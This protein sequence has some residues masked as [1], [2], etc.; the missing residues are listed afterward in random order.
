MTTTRGL[1]GALV[2]A[3][4]AVSVISAQR[5]PAIQTP[6]F[7][8]GT[9]YVSVDVIVTDKDDRVVTNLT[10]EDFEIAE[11]GIRQKIADFAVVSIP[12]ADRAV[13]VDAPP[14]PPSDVASN[15]RSADVSRAIAIVIDDV[16]IRGQD[17]IP[18]KRV[19]VEFLKKLTPDDQIALTWTS[20]SDLSQDFTSD[21]NRLIA[22]VNRRKA[23]V[24]TADF[25]GGR[26]RIGTLRSVVKAMELARQG[27]RAIFFVSGAAC[28]P[29]PVIEPDATSIVRNPDAGQQPR[30]AR[31]GGG[32]LYA[33]C[34]DLIKQAQRVGVAIYTVDPRLFTGA[35]AMAAISA[36]TPEERGALVSEARAADD[37][38]KTLAGATGGRAFSGIS[39]PLKA[40]EHIVRENGSYYLLGYYPDPLVDDGQFH[41]I[42]VLVKRPGLR[43]RARFGYMAPGAPSNKPTTETREMTRELGAGLDDPGLP[44]RA[45][46]APIAMTPK[47]TR[48]MVTVELTYPA[49]AG[50]AV[51]DDLRV[52]V[53]AITPDAKIKASFQ[54]PIHIS[55]K[56]QPDARGRFA[57]NEAIDLPAKQ[58]VLRIGVT[59]R[60]LGRSGTTH[61]SVDV[62]DFGDHDLQVS[63]LVI[64]LPGDLPPDAVMGLD[65]FRTLVPFQ[66]TTVRTFSPSG[67]IRVFSRAY[68]KPD[69]TPVDATLSLTGPTTRP[70]QRVTLQGMG[71]DRS[72]RRSAVFDRSVSLAGLAPGTYV[73]SLEAKAPKGKPQRRDLPIEIR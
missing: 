5:G 49:E 60:A 39:N 48:A 7:R 35:D 37:D 67:S 13:D 28:S 1:L 33:E 12:P 38:L 41:D 62:P 71:A 64:G 63:P 51:N 50:A 73:L 57:I 68:W 43:V 53:L 30:L 65:T 59:S 44:I 4:L 8:S 32:L 46:A 66:P 31:P 20:H 26:S 45:F 15:A 52:G 47:G 22:A 6:V 25:S 72:G 54:R 9:Q 29:V 3:L 19:L 23:A 69:A 40:V 18:L 16:S 36:N 11:R 58:L 42:K 55:G 2:A 56:W 17:L 10:K 24:G 70:A 21:V 61:L 14:G 27:R 34:D